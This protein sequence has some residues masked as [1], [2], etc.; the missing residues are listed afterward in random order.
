MHREICAMPQIADGVAMLYKLLLVNGA[1]VVDIKTFDDEYII[2]TE[3]PVHEIIYTLT[4]EKNIDH[5]P[6]NVILEPQCK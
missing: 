3:V 2:Y 5:L 1:K 4:G 6:I